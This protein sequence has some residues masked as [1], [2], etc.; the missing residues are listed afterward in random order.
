MLKKIQALNKTV[1][2]IDLEF[3]WKF[4][5]NWSDWKEIYSGWHQKCSFLG[6][7]PFWSPFS[8]QPKPWPVSATSLPLVRAATW[9]AQPIKPG[10][11]YE[12]STTISNKNPTVPKPE[13]IPRAALTPSK[14]IACRKMGRKFALTPVVMINAIRRVKLIRLWMTVGWRSMEAFLWFCV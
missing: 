5:K 11:T 8:I 6:A 13:T 1:T 12:L 2:K 9:S 3:S 10:A 7:W 4:G 14:M